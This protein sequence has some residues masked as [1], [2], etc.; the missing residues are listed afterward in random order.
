MSSPVCRSC[1]SRSVEHVGRLPEVFAFA[2]RALSEPIP[3][4]A[5][6]RCTACRMVFRHPILSTEQY[7][8]LYEEGSSEVWEPEDWRQDFSL[9]RRE[10]SAEPVGGDVLDVGCFTGKLLTGLPRS[11]RLH[12]VE[13]NRQAARI[14]TS[15]G[16]TIVCPSMRELERLDMQFDVITASDVIE[17]V[18]DPLHFLQT[19]RQ[20]LRP[21]GRLLVSTG[22]CDA[23]LWRA[24]GAHFWYCYFAEH[25]S[26]VG[27]GWFGS[28]ARRVGF[29]PMRLIP[30][31]YR[32]SSPAAAAVKPLIGATLYA[33]APRLYRRLRGGERGEGAVR[34]APPGCGATQDHVLCV[35]A[36][37]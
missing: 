35:L 23:W 27:R 36:A 33:C 21:S 1:Q 5:L 16:I 17:H 6:W 2:G 30:F 4:G 20:R 19:L 22:D 14:A 32:R 28:M 37:V 12:G 13:P 7:E 24:F 11:Y 18:T 9:I 3:G 29:A 34:F 8:S 10:L 15:R 26:F 25:I 31:N